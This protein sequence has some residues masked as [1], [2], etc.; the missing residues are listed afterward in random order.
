[1]IT[2][3][4]ILHPTTIYIILLIL[5]L[6]YYFCLLLGVKCG[7]FIKKHFR[8][9]YMTTIFIYI[10][11]CYFLNSDIKFPYYIGKVIIFKENS[12]YI[13]ILSFALFYIE[14]F[15]ININIKLVQ[16]IKYFKNDKVREIKDEYAEL[17]RIT[18][19]D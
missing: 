15:C 12:K 13:G 17:N 5:G 10:L 11:Y 8:R 9:F 14:F 19:A 4:C 18:T 7:D 2:F 16:Y 1:M 6:I 3:G